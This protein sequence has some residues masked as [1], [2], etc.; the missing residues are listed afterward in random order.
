MALYVSS[1]NMAVKKEDESVIFVLDEICRAPKNSI[2]LDWSEV[3]QATLDIW[4]NEKSTDKTNTYYKYC[5]YY[6]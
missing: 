4:W 2:L 5:D 3:A 1:T 6:Y